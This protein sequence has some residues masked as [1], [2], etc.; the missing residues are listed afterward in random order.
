MI[1]KSL[2]PW[3][4]GRL[5]PLLI[6]ITLPTVYAA[7]KARSWT[8]RSIETYPSRLTIE[9][10]TIAADPLILDALAGQVFNHP[11]IVSGGILPVAIIISN[12]NDFLIEVDGG[13]AELIIGEK[14][15]RA[16]DPKQAVYRLFYES[17]LGLPFPKPIPTNTVK[18]MKDALQ[19][20]SI[21]FLSTKR[22]EPHATAGGFIYLLD[23]DVGGWRNLASAKLYL[24]K[25]Y[26]RDNGAEMMFFEIDLKAAID[27][28]PEKEGQSHRMGIGF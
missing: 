8:P 15:I 20:F 25:I 28:A 11:A 23:R 13:A 19:D 18:Q 9:G 3:S 2:E 22:V 12:A 16:V 5:L 7:S 26:R 6:F 14:H 21:K 27:A 24:P 1:S 10:V 17:R 4:L